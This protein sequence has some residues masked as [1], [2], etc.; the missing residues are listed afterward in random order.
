M[1]SMISILHQAME[2]KQRGMPIMEDKY[3]N[4]RLDDLKQFED[5]TGV[6]F[7]NSPNCN[8]DMQSIINIKDINKDNLKECQDVAEIVEYSN[9]EEMIVYLDIIGS[10]MI[11]TY[12]NGFLTSIQTNDAN[13]EKNIQS[14]NLPYKIKKDGVYSV[15]GK[16]AITN[17][18]TFYVY[19]VL[20]GSSDNLRYDL[21]KA[22]DLNF[23]IVPFWFANNL[24]SKR[25]KDT[26]DYVFD[27]VAEDD[28][29]CNGTVFKFNEKKFSNILNFVGCYYANYSN[30]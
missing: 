4:I 30:K 13:A 27:Y 28:L 26:I 9:Q 1:T 21:N 18:P 6:M 19:D 8:I 20:E 24:N 12:T 2:S 16:I 23:N 5:E 3:I 22:E 17:K 11:A 25:L 10:D 15:K 14:M 7:V 29:G